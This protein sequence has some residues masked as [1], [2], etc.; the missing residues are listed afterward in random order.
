MPVT[1][2]RWLSG[3]MSIS[4][5]PTPATAVAIGSDIAS[6]EPNATSRMSAAAPIPTADTADSE[7][8]S[9]CEMAS[10]SSSTARPGFLAAVAAAITWLML[11]ASRSSADLVKFTVAYAVRPSGLTWTLPPG[12]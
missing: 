12:W 7:T 4:P 3:A 1:D 11:A 9:E 8:C 5:L 2:V 10:P 6:S